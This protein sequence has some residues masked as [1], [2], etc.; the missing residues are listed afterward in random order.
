MRESLQN[1]AY[2]ITVLEKFLELD[3]RWRALT[4]EGNA[5]RK[6]RNEVSE[7][8]P[9]LSAAEKK[10]KIGEMKAIADRISQ[11]TT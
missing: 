8:V 5:L 7:E 10:L 9:R 2:D 11:I 6:K 4:E 1:R 3:R